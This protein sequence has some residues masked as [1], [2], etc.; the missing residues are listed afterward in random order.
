M[1]LLLFLSRLAFICNLFFLLAV[2][3]QWRNFIGDPALLS[4]IVIICYPGAFL[5][6]PAVNLGYLFIFARKRSWLQ[7]LPNWLIRAN[8]LFL[9]AQ[10]IYI[11]LRHGTFY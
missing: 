2:L 7:S 3:L 4:T 8:I 9:I 5:L 1:R 11:L 10:F 6:N